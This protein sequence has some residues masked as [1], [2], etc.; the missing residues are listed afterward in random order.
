MRFPRSFPTWAT[1]FWSVALLRFLA[2]SPFVI[3]D[4]EAW[5]SAAANAMKSPWDFYRSAVDHKP[6]G[7]VWYYWFVNRVIPCAA[8][9]RII[10]AVYTLLTVAAAGVLGW[11]ASEF[12]RRRKRTSASFPTGWVAA[13]LFLLMTAIPVPKLLSVTAD[14]LIV[15]LTVAAYGVA[16]FFEFPGAALV[17]GVILGFAL[18]IK[19]TAVFFAIP[20]LL[21]QWP[22]KWSWKEIPLFALGAALV[23]APTIV[24]VGWGDFLFWTWSYPK[25]VLTTVREKLFQSNLEMLETVTIYSLATLPCVVILARAAVKRMYRLRDFRV[26]WL[27]SGL[28]A[29]F[30]GKSLFLHYMLLF[31]PAFALLAADA[32]EWQWDRM[33]KFSFPWMGLQYVAGALLLLVPFSGVFWGTD[34]NY[35]EHLSQVLKP[36]LR[37]GERIMIWG[38]SA[39]PLTYTGALHTSRFVLPRF[40]VAPYATAE[41][42]EMFRKEV[43]SDPPELVIDLHERGDNQFDN[44]IDSEASVAELVKKYRVFISESVPWAKFYFR[45]PP[46]SAGGWVEVKAKNRARVYS[47]FPK[48][49]KSWMKL[50]EA[51]QDQDFSTLLQIEW[52]LR[53]H[54]ALELI[55][56]QGSTLQIRDTATSLYARLGVRP[57]S[58]VFRPQIQV[59][60]DSQKI[61]PFPMRSIAWWP[62]LALVELQPRGFGK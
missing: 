62:S 22:R 56:E 28:A 7:V 44:P 51:Y 32:M 4:D 14:G 20:I 5:W 27:F 34:L 60:L 3:D 36:S 61:Q 33:T 50:V 35:F 48:E 6:P 2:V 53:A 10:R 15:I 55:A 17:S 41:T 58:E 1:A 23:V 52:S 12:S 37:P 31:T 9:P 45:T 43:Q 18:L 25:A 29:A 8:D 47:P 11:M 24:G 57:A 46:T 40:G 59:F 26:L 42:S 19:Q 38:G 49:S 30:L 16:L 39:L 21:S 54:A 13:T